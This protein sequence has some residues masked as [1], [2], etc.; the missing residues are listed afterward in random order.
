MATLVRM[1]WSS[2]DGSALEE[3][4][5][6]GRKRVERHAAFVAHLRA[7]DPVFAE[8]SALH[9][10]DNAPWQAAVY[11]LTGCRP[12][13]GALGSRVLADRSI[14]PVVQALARANGRDVGSERA[15]M[16]WAAY[17]WEVERHHH[18]GYPCEFGEYYFRRWM[19]ALHLRHRMPPVPGA[20]IPGRDL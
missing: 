9:G 5:T 16:E 19:T 18:T 12:V 7:R 13:W 3:S 11:L 17:L 10:P 6:R 4:L 8:A 20:D 15:V 1:G 2:D 14:A